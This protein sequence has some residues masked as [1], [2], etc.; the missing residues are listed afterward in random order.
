[1]T[2]F[3]AGLVDDP[4]EEVKFMLEKLQLYQNAY[5]KPLRLPGIPPHSYSEVGPGCYNYNLC[6][7]LYMVNGLPY[8][9]FGS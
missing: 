5:D 3:V 2:R 1:M 7:L 6:L 9:L 8:T 4:N